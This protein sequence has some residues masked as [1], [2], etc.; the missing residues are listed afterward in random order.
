MPLRSILPAAR[1]PPARWKVK[2]CAGE[3][4]PAAKNCWSLCTLM[5]KGSGVG[6]WVKQEGLEVLMAL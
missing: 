1:S 2:S 5:S 6:L 4:P 3:V